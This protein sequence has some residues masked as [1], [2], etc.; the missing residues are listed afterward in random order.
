[1]RFPDFGID[2]VEDHADLVAELGG[3]EAALPLSRAVALV[4][5][6]EVEQDRRVA[7][8]GAD[9]VGVRGRLVRPE[10]EV[11]PAGVVEVLEEVD[12][13]AARIKIAQRQGSHEA[14]M[15]DDQIR[16]DVRPGPQRLVH[17]GALPGNI[18][19]GAAEVV[20]LLGRSTLGV[21]GDALDARELAGPGA[22]G[23]GEAPPWLPAEPRQQRP[24]LR[25]EVLVQE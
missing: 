13:R 6:V 14:G 1:P 24:E 10:V 16:L 25:G 12:D 19:E 3:K 21:E 11:A 5:V 4:A 2:A 22:G 23:E 8:T 17:R 20:R 18:L 9:A 7:E 15:R